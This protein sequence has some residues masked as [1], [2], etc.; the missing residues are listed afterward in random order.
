MLPA[1]VI[2]YDRTTNRAQVQPLIAVVTTANQVVQR[3]QSSVPV[4]QYGGGGFVLSFPV[5]TGDTG[6]SRPTTATF[7]YSSRRPLPHRRTPPG[8]TTSPTPC[9]SP[10]PS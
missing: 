2:A 9:S 5:M 8:C 3:A 1:Q 4:F 6:G 7:H 10:T